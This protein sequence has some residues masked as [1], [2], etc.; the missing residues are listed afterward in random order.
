MLRAEHLNVS[1]G[2]VQVL[3]NVSFNLEKKQIVTILG[4]NGAGKSTLLN[5]IVG[6]N[7]CHPGGKIVFNETEIQNSSPHE[8]V[9]HGLALAPEGRRLFLLMDVKTNLEL[10]AYTKR[11]RDR[12]NESLDFVYTLFPVL[13]ERRNQV[14]RTLS[15]GEQQMVN[16]GRALMSRPDLLILD[17]PSFGL[18]PLLVQRIFDTVVELNKQGL[19]IV[20]VE[21]RAV[22]ALRVSDR[23]YVLSEG[24]VV[25]EGATSDVTNDERIRKAYLGL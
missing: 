4:Y 14:C 16:I 12:I 21:Q 9:D 7:R 23:A 8:I 5:T 17:E 18:S 2:R 20:V 13:K 1:Y 11:G 15:G 6:L 25:L 24:R 19:T 10:G 3:W 22:D